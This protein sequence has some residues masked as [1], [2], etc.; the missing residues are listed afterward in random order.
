MR[1]CDVDAITISFG[2]AGTGGF[3]I[4]N[5]SLGSYTGTQQLIVTVFMVL[6][7]I[8]F[9]AYFL[10]L[11]G[12]W[13]QGIKFEEVR[14]YLLIILVSVLLIGFDIRSLYGS[15]SEA[16]ASFRFPSSFNYN[17]DGVFDL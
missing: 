8:N 2:T 11:F 17:D 5:D 16:F 13:R 3:G 4:R 12:K 7:G 9:S 10:I 1:R 14:W 6:F 15:L